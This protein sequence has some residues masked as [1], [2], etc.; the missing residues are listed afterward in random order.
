[1]GEITM[2][3]F[4]I[5]VGWDL[6][7]AVGNVPLQLHNWDVEFAVC[8]CSYKYLNSGPGGIAGIFVHEKHT[9]DNSI[10]QFKPRL[11]GWW[12][13]NDSDRFKMLEVFDPIKSALSYRQSNPSV[14]DVVAVKSS[15]ELFKKVGGISELR[16]KSVELTGFLQALLT[17]SKYYIKQEE[18]T[19]RLGFEIL[20]ST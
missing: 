5:L 17:S 7:H 19:D 2:Y 18:T 4:G 10:E 12:G 6:A 11:A 20:K 13:N 14:I 3:S 8:W 9:K 16:K 15:L 1:M